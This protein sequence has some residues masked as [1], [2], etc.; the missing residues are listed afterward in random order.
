[1]SVDHSG[2]SEVNKSDSAPLFARAAAAASRAEVRLAGVI[3]DYFRSEEDR[4]DDR[5]RT[6]TAAMLRATV[7]TIAQ[8]LSARASDHLGDH[9][10]RFCTT[11]PPRDVG[12]AALVHRLRVSGLLRDRALMAEL[13]AQVRQ[14][15]LSAALLARGAAG[16]TPW[17][18]DLAGSPDRALAGAARAYLDAESLRRSGRVADLPDMLRERLIWW[19]A[20][21]LRERWAV[22]APSR[23]AVDRAITKAAQRSMS[24]QNDQDRFD[25]A[26]DRLAAALGRAPAA[27]PDHLIRA[28][29]E[30]HLLLF[31]TLLSQALALDDREVRALVFDVHGEGLWLA[32]RAAD[33]DR[34][35][36]ARI[37]LLLA[38]ADPR[39]DIE[40]LADMLDAIA[41]VAP[42][43][44]MDSLALLALPAEFRSAVRALDNAVMR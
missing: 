12:A 36:I 21:A 41:Q 1:M 39:R 3:D 11:T 31:I 40:T 27:L 22:A 9:L 18:H 37:G 32:L 17:L 26:A 14:D 28:L 34:V 5:T 24:A 7:Q 2:A 29:E 10:G 33:L 15:H 43:E 16:A 20:A 30:G 6:A 8:D 23:T 44:A 4:L 35:A 42:D 38:D 19:V 25:V 13:F